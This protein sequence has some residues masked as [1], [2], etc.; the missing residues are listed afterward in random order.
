[1]EIKKYYLAP[2]AL[3]PNS[4]LPLLHYVG[5]IAPGDDAKV[6]FYDLL[7]ANNWELQWLVRYGP[8]QEAHYHSGIHECMA[9]L[10]GEATIRFGAADTTPDLEASTNGGGKEPGGFEIQAHAGD[11]FLI[12]AGVCHKTFNPIPNPGFERLTPGDGHS[13]DAADV[14]KFVSEVELSGFTMMGCYPQGH[15]TWDFLTG[16]EGN[17]EKAWS[18]P[19]PERDPILGTS[20]DGI[21][22]TWRW[23]N[24]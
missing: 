19:I 24:H 6:R 7:R 3:V 16:G 9:V 20:P 8:T 22:G 11:V 5:A 10:S 18:V 13:V 1:M 23:P 17:Y 4:P 14:R 2:T 15:G 12:P 21:L